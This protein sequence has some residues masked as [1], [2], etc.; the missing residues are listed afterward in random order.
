MGLTGFNAA[1]RRL[2]TIADTVL[3]AALEAEADA[4]KSEDKILFVGWPG[5]VIDIGELG[6]VTFD[7]DGAATVTHQQAGWLAQK[8]ADGELPNPADEEDTP[9][10]AESAAPGDKP[11]RAGKSKGKV[12]TD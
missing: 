12:K 7:G 5:A 4:A 6:T 1:R 3:N 11:G 9:P 8:I 10:E 2:K